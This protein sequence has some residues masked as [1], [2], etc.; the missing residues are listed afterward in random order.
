VVVRVL[1]IVC[2][3]AACDQGV[4]PK[5]D[6]PPTPKDAAT[7]KDVATPDAL[8]VTP[9]PMVKCPKKKVEL[10]P[11]DLVMMIRTTC[12]GTCPAYQVI[13]DYDGHVGFVGTDYVAECEA[14]AMIDQQQL[15]S[16][17]RLFDDKHFFELKD[18]YTHED[19]TDNP[20]VE[21]VYQPNADR[22][23]ASVGRSKRV[24]HYH[25]DDSAPAALS[26]LEDEVDRILGTARWTTI[27]QR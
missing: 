14:S 12:Y 18:A 22:Y 13:V 7:P 27:I 25:G 6:V 10:R 17:K 19:W 2:L 5:H 4:R 11:F 1:A 26:E 3:V 15:Q 16:L 21:L 8:V 23:Q 20:S 9:R 24:E